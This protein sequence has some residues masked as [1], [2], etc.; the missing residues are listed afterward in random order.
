M[1]GDSAHTR[2]WRYTG[3]KAGKISDLSLLDDTLAS[4]CKGDVRVAVKAVGLNFADVFTCLGL[5][6]AFPGVGVPG[7]EFSG[8]VEEI[9]GDGAPDRAG[10]RDAVTETA[11]GAVPRLKVGDR[12]MGVTR[13]GAFAEQVV[14]PAHQVNALPKGWSFEQGAAFLVQG[15]T[16]LYGLKSLGDVRKG[17]RV[18]VHSA[19][20]GVGLFALAIC[21]AVGAT[22]VATVGSDSKVEFLLNRFPSLSKVCAP[23]DASTSAVPPTRLAF[24]RPVPPLTSLIHTH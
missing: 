17:H 11:L 5:Y 1:V 24:T 12:V 16:A 19:A 2:A 21:Q 4:P 15:L 3:K 9:A 13:F 10:Q 8:V 14:L 23:S 6:S 7:L 22:P 18:L 20:G